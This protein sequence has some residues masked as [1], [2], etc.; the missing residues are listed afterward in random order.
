M[1][2]SI[3]TI[4]LIVGFI[5]NVYSQEQN[6][7]IKYHS[8]KYTLNGQLKT[9][10]EIKLLLAQNPASASEFQK[11]KST[12]ALGWTTF[13]SGYVLAG[14]GMVIFISSSVE[15]TSNVLYQ[16]DAELPHGGGGFIIAGSV[17]TLTGLV[18]LASNPHFKRS[19]NLYNSSVKSVG[20]KPVKINL[21]V[22]PNS[23]GL[24][25]TF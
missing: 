18:I 23:L 3:V 22:N 6:D 15:E 8:G 10:S 4:V 24:R 21:T 25:M 19:I 11:Y 9:K 1:K 7:S 20:L 16:Q 5:L 13:A 17:A 2:N 12:K 14:I